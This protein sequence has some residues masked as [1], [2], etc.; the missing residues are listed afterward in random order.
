MS[1]LW[2][3]LC[4]HACLFHASQ[5]SQSS[6]RYIWIRSMIIII[7]Y[8]SINVVFTLSSHTFECHFIIVMSVGIGWWWWWWWWEY[9][10]TLWGLTIWT[11]AKRTFGFCSIQW[12]WKQPTV[13]N[14][15]FITRDKQVGEGNLNWSDIIIC[16]YHHH[17]M[18]MLLLLS[19][20]MCKSWWETCSSRRKVVKEKIMVD[21][22]GGNSW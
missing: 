12:E 22:R 20:K 10:T 3:S 18:I 7:S 2:Q 9:N 5:N 16:H 6:K 17:C 4:F 1:T 15:S 14:N 21:E 13:H 19:L 11:V 8:D